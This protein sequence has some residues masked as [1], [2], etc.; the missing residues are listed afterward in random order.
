MVEALDDPGYPTPGKLEL[1]WGEG[2]MSPGGPA[3]VARIIAGHDIGGCHVRDIGC[4]LGG[5]DVALIRDH[6]AASMCRTKPL[7]AE[8]HRVLRPGGRLFISDWLR[9]AAPNA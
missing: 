3:E 2:F 6:A 1:I 5:A 7:Y 9:G 4:G 8:A